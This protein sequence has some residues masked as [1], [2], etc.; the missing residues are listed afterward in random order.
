M[1]Y[2]SLFSGAGLGDFGFEMAGLEVAWQCELDKY[3][4][5]VLDLRW[6][7]VK[8]YDDIRTINTDELERVDLI[9]GGFPCQPFSQAGKQRGTQDNRYLWPE[10]LRIIKGVRPR[11]VVAENVPGIINMAFDHVCSS[12]ESEGFSVQTIVFPSH[13]LGAPHKRDRVWIIAN[14]DSEDVQG[15]FTET[16]SNGESIGAIPIPFSWRQWPQLLSTPVLCRTS[17]GIANR[18][19]RTKLLGNGQT[20]CSTY[21]IGKWL[22]EINAMIG[23]EYGF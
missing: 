19:D 3:A 16:E 12:L 10:M 11:W 23:G 14:S 5:Q 1:R 4:R 18:V 22:M 20:P 21:V 13:A 2:G 8:K 17:D 6:P 7:G 15:G 9:T